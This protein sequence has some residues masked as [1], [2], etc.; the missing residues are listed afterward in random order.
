V[1][2]IVTL[3]QEAWSARRNQTLPGKKLNNNN[4]NIEIGTLNV[5]TLLPEWRIQELENAL[6]NSGI[7]ILGLSEVRRLGESINLRKS[8]YIL[9]QYGQNKG[10]TP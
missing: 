10:Q 3:L 9:C 8:G 7:L 2:F 6:S 1:L 4:T 5:R